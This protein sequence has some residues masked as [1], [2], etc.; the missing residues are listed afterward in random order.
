[1]LHTRQAVLAY[2]F[3]AAAIETFVAPLQAL[4][5][6]LLLVFAAVGAMRDPG[7]HPALR[8]LF[9]E[10]VLLGCSTAG[11]ICGDGVS[12]A[13]CVL[14]AVQFEHTSLVHARAEVGTMEASGTTGIE[15]ARQLQSDDLKAVLLLG[16]GVQVNG[17]A[18]AEGIGQQLGNGVKITG[19]L[20]GDGGAFTGTL[21]LDDDG[22]HASAAVAIGLCGE[23][24]RV[25]HG[26]YGGWTAFGHV[27]TIT[28]A[29]GNVLLELDH[30]PALE[31]YKKY[32]GEYARDLPASGLLFPLSLL[33]SADASSD[34]G[35]LR[36]IL[37]IDEAA[38]SLIL[39]GDVPVGGF[40]RLMQSDTDSLITGAS[41]AADMALAIHG[42]TPETGT[43]LAMLVSCVGRKLVMGGRVDEEIEAV[44]DHLGKCTTLTGF[45][46]YGEIGPHCAG[47]PPLLHNQT[48]TLTLLSED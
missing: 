7:F 23:H 17:S 9:P 14:T 46:S 28:A 34:T 13:R 27:R 3:E 1:M 16:P 2:P 6:Q 21:T 31:I 39:A 4:S 19:G 41:K 24:L 42:E 36:T 8:A 33:S 11:E 32:L 40:V 38:G 18:L 43:R 12:D 22:I 44:G 45:Y 29:R 30:E 20:A 25:G 15:L 26:S 47:G 37:G 5:P 48:M 10:A 35:I